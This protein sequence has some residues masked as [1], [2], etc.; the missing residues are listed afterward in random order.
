M[1]TKKLNHFV[2]RFYLKAWATSDQI[3]CLRDGSIFQT[4]VRNVAAENRFYRLW[5][6]SR[7]DIEFV[8]E[9]GIKDSP[10]RLKPIHER[11]L[12][13]FASVHDA[14]AHLKRS[15]GGAPEVFAAID[16][17]I[18]E[19][20]ENLHLSVEETFQP[21][22]ERLRA[23]DRTFLLE[24]QP[25][26]LF[27]NGLAVQYMRTHHRRRSALIL[28]PED[29]A[30]YE[31]IANVLTHIFAMNL[32]YSLFVDH[33]RLKLM[34]LENATEVPFVTAD[35]PV[36]NMAARLKDTTAPER[37]EAYYP[38]S[39]TKAL[40]VLGPDSDFLPEDL[41]VSPM[42]A[43]LYNLRIASR[44]CQQVFASSQEE[45]RAIRD[46]LPAFV[47]SL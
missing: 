13:Q 7:A 1:P 12:R 23:G 35:Q 17:D 44:A 11:L 30:R 31:R 5:E 33:P 47:D 46:L 20:N 28:T 6:L 42:T 45:L 36:I 19:A 16:R 34:I 14:K 27:Y 39:P 18:A 40:L 4:N 25:T 41:T 29:F 38:L 9:A 21:Y 37:F 3:W 26:A 2:A 15:N 10:E 43:H 8:R 22:L 24:D 32:G